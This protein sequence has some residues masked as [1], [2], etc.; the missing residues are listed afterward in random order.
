M[1]SLHA[2]NAKYRPENPVNKAAMEAFA[3]ANSKQPTVRPIAQ[4][5]PLLLCGSADP[6]NSKRV[7]KDSGVVKD[8]KA[9][10][11]E[12]ITK[13]AAAAGEVGGCCVPLITT[14]TSTRSQCDC[15]PPT[16]TC[17][18]SPQVLCILCPTCTRCGG[19]PQQHCHSY[20]L[21]T[22]EKITAWYCIT[23]SSRS[24]TFSYHLIVKHTKHALYASF[25]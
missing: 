14:I 19:L 23:E 3:L 21:H 20:I 1:P 17:S 5:V 9:Q 2:E 10:A 11:R 15:I 6:S 24:E 12:V 25:F 7:S 8:N 22:V 13:K 4:D 16:E 18:S